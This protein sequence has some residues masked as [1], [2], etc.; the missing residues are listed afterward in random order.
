MLNG[1]PRS[2][3]VREWTVKH[4]CPCATRVPYKGAVD[5]CASAATALYTRREATGHGATAF[6]VFETQERPVQ[7]REVVTLYNIIAPYQTRLSDLT[8]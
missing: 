5:G 1:I 4:R 7:P 6:D 2:N 3:H 8:N